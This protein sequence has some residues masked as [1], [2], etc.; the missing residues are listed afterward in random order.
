MG[1]MYIS[2]K[3]KNPMSKFEQK[4]P[5]NQKPQKSLVQK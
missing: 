5:K 2:S 1:I 4:Q 3:N